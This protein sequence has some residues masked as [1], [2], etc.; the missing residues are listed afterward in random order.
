ME[1]H[2]ATAL[3]VPIEHVVTLGDLDPVHLNRTP[4][5]TGHQDFGGDHLP[6]GSKSR[7]GRQFTSKKGKER[8]RET[9]AVN[10]TSS[11]RRQRV[12]VRV[13]Q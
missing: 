8:E 4:G 10:G 13:S 9:L 1:G 7:G 2:P 12:R 11:E 3:A 5:L 6:L